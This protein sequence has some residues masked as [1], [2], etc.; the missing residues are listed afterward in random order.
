M[1]VNCCVISDPIV[2]NVSTSRLTSVTCVIV[3]PLRTSITYTML[4][5]L[6]ISMTYAI[7]VPLQTLACTMIVPLQALKASE[8]I[9]MS[10]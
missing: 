4:C 2:I 6:R 1:S 3:V 10:I 5:P 9:I 7:V 8:V